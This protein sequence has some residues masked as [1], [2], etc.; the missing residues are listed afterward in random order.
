MSKIGLIGSIFMMLMMCIGASSALTI[1]GS[2]TAMPLVEIMAE[3]AP[4]TTTVTGGGSGVGVTNVLTG[5]SDIGMV[6]RSLKPEETGLTATKFAY[7]GIVIV[8]SKGIGVSDITTE[9]LKG[10]YAGNITNWKELGGIDSEICAVSR[11][12]GSG[13]Q[14]TFNTDIMG[15]KKASLDG[16]S[17]VA[18]SNSE[19]VQAVIRSDTA[20]GFVGFNFANAASMDI[21]SLNGVMPTQETIKE[22]KY[23]LSRELCFVTL[24]D[25]MSPDAKQFIEYALSAEGQSIA[26]EMGYIPI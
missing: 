12:A 21:L 11:E 24:T 23:M 13:T 25:Q 4:V 2:T 19:V 6:S 22:K 15:D 1:S 10:I 5:L 18:G 9:Q 17:T 20:V 26:S 3:T 7:D 14:E 8:T 16:S